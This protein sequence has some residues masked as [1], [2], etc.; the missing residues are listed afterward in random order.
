MILSNFK[1]IILI[2]L[3]NFNKIFQNVHFF[4]DI[5]RQPVEVVAASLLP[6]TTHRPLIPT[7]PAPCL[8][9][10]IT[11]NDTFIDEIGKRIGPKGSILAAFFSGISGIF[12]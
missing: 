4:T 8:L 12:R 1:C 10:S 2:I 11:G 6:V 3:G 9:R 7:G 5:P